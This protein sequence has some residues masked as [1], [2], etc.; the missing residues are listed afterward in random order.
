M[1]DTKAQVEAEKWIREVY[2]PKKYGQS[3]RQKNLDLQSKGQFK[4]DAVSDD[5]EIVAVISTSVGFTSS[6]K[7][8]TA[9]L[10]KIR[11]DALWF[12]MLERTPEKRLMIFTEQSMID[13]VKDEKKKGRFPS[14]FEILKVTLPPDL[15]AKVAESQRIASEEV[16]PT[17]KPI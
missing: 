11:S 8:A 3:F 2:L 13:L 6:G 5:G 7:V 14:E 4:F 9:K 17:R 16:S 15:A 10:M 12:V 1:A